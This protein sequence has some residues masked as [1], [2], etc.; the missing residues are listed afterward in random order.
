MGLLCSLDWK[1]GGGCVQ[2]IEVS[3]SIVRSTSLK[4]CDAPTQLKHVVL[5]PKGNMTKG[6]SKIFL[7]VQRGMGH[8]VQIEKGS[9]STL[10]PKTHPE[11]L[12]LP[13]D[14]LLWGHSGLLL[15]CS[16][17]V[18]VDGF[19]QILC[20]CIFLQNNAKI[21]KD[22]LSEFGDKRSKDQMRN[23]LRLSS[24]GCV[25]QSPLVESMACKHSTFA[26]V[27]QHVEKSPPFG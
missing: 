12:G 20:P 23:V 19:R 16:I 9:T 11:R 13:F 1:G 15:P 17:L 25:P 14:P 26:A 6:S 2:H 8:S 21:T 22:S 10:E 3:G 27:P 5:V 18:N 7:P 4:I 24:C